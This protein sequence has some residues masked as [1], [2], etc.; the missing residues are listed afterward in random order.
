M[1]KSQRAGQ[2]RGRVLRR[3][4]GGIRKRRGCGG[5][6]VVASHSGV[7]AAAWPVQQTAAV[8]GEA[9]ARLARIDSS[10]WH[11]GTDRAGQA[12]GEARRDE[13]GGSGKW[14]WWLWWLWLWWS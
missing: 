7:E 1:C 8:G 12:Q 14:R 4:A 13:T 6:G 2:H 3:A 10:E 5:G 11:G 9:T